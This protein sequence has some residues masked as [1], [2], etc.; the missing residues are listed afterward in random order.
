MIRAEKRVKG[1]PEVGANEVGL[2]LGVHQHQVLGNELKVCQSA[3]AALQ[4]I[5]VPR[6]LDCTHR[7]DL[8]GQPRVI[9]TS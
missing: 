4:V 5:A 2:V 1:F 6:G 9:T 3:D 8:P 7:A